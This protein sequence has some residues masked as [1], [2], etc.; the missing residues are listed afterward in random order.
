LLAASIPRMTSFILKTFAEFSEELF[1]SVFREQEAKK[2][3]IIF[4]P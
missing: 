4:K 2:K 1:L 3:M